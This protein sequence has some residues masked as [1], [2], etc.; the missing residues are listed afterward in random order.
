MFHT[1]RRG[2]PSPRRVASV[3]PPRRAACARSPLRPV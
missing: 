3:R 1:V 2:E